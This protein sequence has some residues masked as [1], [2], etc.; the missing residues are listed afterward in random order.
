M[1]E[2]GPT[3][4]RTWVQ[5]LP[6]PLFCHLETEDRECL[7]LTRLLGKVRGAG[8]QERALLRCQVYEFPTAAIANDHKLQWLNSTHLLFM[9]LAARSQKW[10][11]PGEKHG[12]SGAPFIP[13]DSGEGSRS[14]LSPPAYGL[15]LRLH[16]QLP[17]ARFSHYIPLALFQTSLPI[18][19]TLGMTLGSPR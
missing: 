18:S 6:P 1:A 16:G 15:F 9:V 13:E 5:I 12:V 7:L 11:S 3:G 19:R 8:G 17:W 10:V 14:L 2:P 4:R